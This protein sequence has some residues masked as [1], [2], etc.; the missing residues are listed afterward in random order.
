MGELKRKEYEKAE[1][2]KEKEA[3]KM[4]KIQKNNC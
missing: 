3:K 2:E 4:E 1:V